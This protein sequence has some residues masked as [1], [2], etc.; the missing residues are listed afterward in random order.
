MLAFF[1]QVNGWSN[2]DFSSFYRI[3]DINT[4]IW[5]YLHFVTIDWEYCWNPYYGTDLI[6]VY[7]F[8]VRDTVSNWVSLF[9]VVRN[10]ILLIFK[11][12]HL[13]R[14]AGYNGTVCRSKGFLMRNYGLLLLMDLHLI[15][16]HF[17]YYTA[18]HCYILRINFGNHIFHLSA[19]DLQFEYWK[20]YKKAN[21]N[22]WSMLVIAAYW[23]SSAAKAIHTYFICGFD[24]L[25]C[26]GGCIEYFL[27]DCDFWSFFCMWIF[28]KFGKLK[29]AKVI[30]FYLLLNFWVFVYIFCRRIVQNEYIL[31]FLFWVLFARSLKFFLLVL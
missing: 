28:T 21:M 4:D 6:I 3:A 5:P 17:N 22:A 25:D 15:L 11:D 19:G 23:S 27:P 13:E 30:K 10:Y 2:F 29:I 18:I 7:Y 12:H 14:N 1:Y 26:F 24:Y 31:I 9:Q 16:A 8:L 20:G